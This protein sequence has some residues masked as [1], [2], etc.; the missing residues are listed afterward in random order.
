LIFP[1]FS[2]GV[3]AQDA[4]NDWSEAMKIN[5]GSKLTI[6]TKMG[7]KFSGKLSSVTAD[8]ITLSTSKA[9]GKDVSLKRE[10][11]AEIRRR[12][13]SAYRVYRRQS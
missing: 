4:K 2:Q 10:E 5:L 11:I 12:G 6:K 1:L 9:P 13:R 7:P 8:L 3:L